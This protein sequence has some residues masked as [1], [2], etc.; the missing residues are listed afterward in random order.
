MLLG[1]YSHTLDEKSRVI[2]PAK[3]REDLG[4]TF[5]LTK[6]IDGCLNVYSLE[7]WKNFE[8]KLAALPLSDENSRK[9]VR[10]FTSG[11]TMCEMDKQGRIVIPS[12][13]KEFANLKKDVIFTGV[14]T[15]AEIWDVDMWK[16][17]IG[18]D[19]ADL[20]NIANHMS[21]FGIWLYISRMAK[22]K[23]KY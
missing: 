21:S 13:L 22:L 17:Y 16:K 1:E 14:S 23:K 7:Q 15:R 3:Y 4:D 18:Q 8:L 5:V 11:A 10:Y 9:F 12:N 6:G 2:V 20:N 19:A